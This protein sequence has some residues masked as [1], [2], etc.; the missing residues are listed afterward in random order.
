MN[1]QKIIQAFDKNNNLIKEFDKTLDAMN[2]INHKNR[3]SIYNC[4]KGITQTAGGYIWK[5]KEN[6]NK[7]IKKYVD[8]LNNY[9]NLGIINNNDYSN[10][11]INKN[12][13]I[14]NNKYKNRKVKTFIN[15]NGYK[16][17]FLYFSTKEKNQFQ[18]HRLLGKYFLKNGDK[19]YYNNKYVINHKDE[20]KK[21]N[22]INNLEWT[23]YKENTNH[24]CAKKVA[25][26][27]INTN[28]ILKIYNSITDAYKD[29]GQK[30]SSLISKV[31]M[32]KEKGR[33]TIYGFKWKYVE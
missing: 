9:I 7:D 32:G 14:V 16:V 17:V 19:Y 22:N 8:N 31:C 25:K 23:T 6:A 24:S 27:D 20:N 10:Y 30:R 13:E 2:F 1:K 15:A 4:L 18:V 5:Y 3:C 21:N 11:N 28:K 33:K 29:I 12:G 26:V